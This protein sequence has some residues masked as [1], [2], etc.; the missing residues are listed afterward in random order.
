MCYLGKLR[1]RR[2][3]W[4]METRRNRVS[5]GCDYVFK[6][7]FMIEHALDKWESGLFHTWLGQIIQKGILLPGNETIN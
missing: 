3:Y 2:I 4:S 1:L 7:W 6:K 5:V